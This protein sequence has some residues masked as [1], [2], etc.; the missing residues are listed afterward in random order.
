MEKKKHT[1]KPNINVGDKFLTKN[2]G[3]AVVIEYVSCYD[4]LVRFDNGHEQR[5]QLDALRKGTI[6]NKSIRRVI[7]SKAKQEIKPGDIFKTKNCGDVVVIAVRASDDVEVEFSDGY[8]K[9]TYVNSLRDGAVQNPNTPTVYGVGFIAENEFSHN[10]DRT[11]TREYSLWSGMMTRCYNPKYHEKKPT[12]KDVTVC[13]EWLHFTNFKTWLHSQHEFYKEG[14]QIDKDILKKNNKV[15]CPSLCV[16]VPP[17]VNSQLT[18]ANSRRGDYPIGVSWDKNKNT[19]MACYRA[20]GKTRHIGYFSTPEKA[21][22]AYKEA[23]EKHL[24]V[25]AD[26][27]A[28]EMDSRVVEALYNYQVE[29]T[30]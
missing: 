21:F 22:Y 1:N 6:R 23:K 3:E 24:K 17:E 18:K 4:V 8:R 14:W 29:I 5:F 10:P 7:N 20:E 30:D 27:Y 19:F 25:I 11:I 15:Y 9:I 16:F 13:D 28:S 2:Y 12:Y 26:K